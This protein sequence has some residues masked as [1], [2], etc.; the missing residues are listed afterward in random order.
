[1][2][3]L[4]SSTVS[5]ILSM[6]VIALFTILLF[7]AGYV[8][9]Q[10]SVKSIQ[11]ALRPPERASQGH[12]SLGSTF[13]SPMQPR[14]NYAYLQLLSQP[15]PSDICSAILFFKQI[16]TNGSAIHDRLFMYPQEWDR[17][18]TAKIS[19]PAATALAILR[20]ASIKYGI[21]LLPIDMTA[22]TSMGYEPTNTKLLRLGQVQFM[23]YD[24]VLYLKTPGIVL[25]T[26]KLDDIL[27][28]RPLPLVF[29]RD[30]PDSVNNEAWIPTPLRPD[31]DTYLP[32]AYL[33]TVN[34]VATGNVQARTHI[35][36]V[37]LP[38]FGHLVMGTKRFSAENSEA[39]GYVF[40]DNDRDGHVKWDGNPLF[41]TWRTQ[42]YEVCDGLDF[43]D[44]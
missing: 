38:G 4:T 39:P 35:P 19:K 11:I 26:E 18:S 8:L 40:F 34:N 27:L 5:A 30:R 41:G 12:G 37:N 24:S 2:V 13:Q 44:Y 20:A 1:M 3:L 16:A 17:M 28:S 42:Q 14:G 36:N 43:E 29:D 21:W 22:A 25:D 9:Q 7:L 23:Q 6:G 33:I 31:R 32:P 15:D 10:Q